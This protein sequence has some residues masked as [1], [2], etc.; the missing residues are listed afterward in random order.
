MEQII[1]C[2]MHLMDLERREIQIRNQL[3]TKTILFMTMQELE[4]MIEKLESALVLTDDGKVAQLC[5]NK[6]IA[7]GIILHEENRQEQFPMGI[8]CM[9]GTDDLDE[10]YLLKIFQRAKHIP[11]TILKTDRLYL[12]EIT[13]KDVPRLYELYQEPS[14]TAYMEDLFENPA[15]EIVYT[16][17]YIKNV[18]EFYGYGIWVIV[19]KETNEVIGR[20]GVESKDSMEGLELGFMLGVDY[21]HKGYALEICKAIIQY[22]KTELEEE[23]I[24]AMVQPENVAS[25]NLCEKLGMHTDQILFDGHYMYRYS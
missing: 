20:A 4:R 24:R 18:Y 25:K 3:H 16:E 5:M 11:W 9:E 13:V 19:L 6:K 10:A 14:I 1:F 22:A 15:E 2:L 17:D 8:Y 23:N 7:V 12:R 21:Q